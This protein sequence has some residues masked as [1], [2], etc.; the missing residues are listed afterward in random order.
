[1]GEC[2]VC[3]QAPCSLQT[4]P[5]SVPVTALTEATALPPGGAACL[6]AASGD[7]RAPQSGSAAY[8]EQFPFLERGL[9]F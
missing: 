9:L 5:A 3:N 6:P 2:R 7:G 8:A 1:M 4:V